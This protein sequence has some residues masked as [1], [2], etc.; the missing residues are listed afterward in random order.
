MS[1]VMTQPVLTRIKTIYKYKYEYVKWN[2]YMIENNEKIYYNL[3]EE[4]TF[5]GFMRISEKLQLNKT[6]QELDF[7]DVDLNSDN[8]LYI[9]PFLISLLPSP[10]ANKANSTIKNFFACFKSAFINKDMDKVHY[11]F[12]FVSEP[13]EN[14]LGLSKNGTKNGRGFGEFNKLEMIESIAESNAI[15]NNL[16]SNI[17]DII[18]F[19]DNIDKDKLS[20]V[21]TNIIRWCLI[22]YTQAQCEMWGIKMIKGETLPFWDPVDE[23][24]QVADTNLLVID[25]EEIILIP[26][27]IV[28]PMNLFHKDQYKYYEIYEQEIRFNLER[29]TSLVEMK[30][31]KNGKTKYSL[32]KKKFGKV[33]Q[34]KIEK[35][36]NSAKEYIREY[37]LKHPTLFQEFQQRTKRKM[38]SLTNE[39]IINK[40]NGMN[41]DAII[42]VLIEKLRTI[43]AGNKHATKFHQLVKSLLAMIFYPYL[44]NPMV[45]EEI[46]EGRKRID[47]VMENNGLD[48]F[49]EK[50]KSV[51]NIFCP[52]IVI[53]CKNY[54]DDI[55]NPGIDQ[56]SGRFGHSRG[57]FGLLVCREIANHD[58]LIKRC[59]DTYR[60]GRGLILTLTDNDIIK[61][62][63]YIQEDSPSNVWRLLEEKKR[64][65]MMC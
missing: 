50:L 47:I 23:E 28:S 46:H 63:E 22:E 55:S 6:Q 13:K 60:D 53:E 51:S 7:L 4:Q 11:L 40:L 27:A 59:Q 44:V 52:Y 16:V 30:K 34:I 57:Q 58:R 9:D 19:V 29:R 37:T 45:E 42:D 3:I 35:E 17:E 54:K 26:K 20:D 5:G 48:G 18:I 64:R 65:I 24:W 8:A 14:C 61:M 15:E 56:L 10:F 12:D 62:L 21:V 2:K 49:F 33:L 25:G 32:P 1:C 41:D 39:E 31:L 38:N 36:Y 43:P